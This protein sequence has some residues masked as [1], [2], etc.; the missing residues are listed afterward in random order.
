MTRTIRTIAH[1]LHQRYLLWELRQVNDALA[2]IPD[3]LQALRYANACR[4]ADADLAAEHE[5]ARRALEGEQRRSVII[6]QIAGV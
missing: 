3:E 6:R 5:A 4:A 1:R 2:A